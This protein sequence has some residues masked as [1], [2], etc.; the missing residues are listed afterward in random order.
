MICRMILMS[1]RSTT[2]IMSKRVQAL[3]KITFKLTIMTQQ[4]FES[5]KTWVEKRTGLTFDGINADGEKEV[6]FDGRTALFSKDL[7]CDG[8]VIAYLEIGDEIAR[9]WITRLGF[10]PIDVAFHT[11]PNH[12]CTVEVFDQIVCRN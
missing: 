6:E 12:H 10:E 2:S 11:N 3:Y 5:T 4:E 8:N 1:T 7:D 9:A